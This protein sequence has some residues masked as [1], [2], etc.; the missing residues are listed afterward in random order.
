MPRRGTETKPA[1]KRYNIKVSLGRLHQ[2]LEDYFKG[3]AQL[4][5]LRYDMSRRAPCKALAEAQRDDWR[6]RAR[7]RMGGELVFVRASAWNETDTG[8]PIHRFVVALTKDEAEGLASAWVYGPTTVETV[9]PDKL[10]EL[11]WI[12]MGKCLEEG[13]VAFP[14]ERTWVTSWS[15][16]GEAKRKEKHP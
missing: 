2:H 8:H 16:A 12:L 9:L 14:G 1:Q 11:A 3:K 6:K 7:E 13:K 15:V 5:T 10:E 4:I